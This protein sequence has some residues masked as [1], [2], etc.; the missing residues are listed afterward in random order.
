MNN[1]AAHMRISS[2]TV[3]DDEMAS[4][5]SAITSLAT[6][7]KKDKCA[8]SIVSKATAVAEALG[9]DGA[10]SPDLGNEVQLAIQKRSP[11]FLY[12]ERL[13][14]V[15]ICAG[16]SMISIL[17]N[18][19]S[20]S[21]WTTTDIYAVALWSA[22]SYQ[23]ALVAERREK[24]RSEVLDA[25]FDWCTTAAN[26]ARD[27]VD[28]PDPL[29]VEIIIHDGDGV[30]HNF[31]EAISKTI[32]ALRRNAALDREEL[33]FLWW[34]QLDRSRLLDKQFSAIAEP[35]RIVAAGIEGAKMLRRLPCEVHREIVLRTLDKNPE[36]DL[37]EMLAVIG[38]DREKLSA[39]LIKANVVAHPTVFPFLHALVCGEV[40]KIGA[41]QKRNVS[42]WGERALL[43]AG[44]ARLMSQGAGKV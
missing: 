29:D 39:S 16:M 40:D 44:L 27:R 4:R 11:S 9:G 10:P 12:E 22:L 21:E 30:S 42:E 14:D 26:K 31:K 34:A 17:D 13:L 1:L 33:D 38:D 35:T 41:S 20:T 5:Q 32:E 2:A 15:G 3:N 36:L 43:E 23:P 37:A 18:N 28:V 25:A 7:W 19:P 24:L 6:V 8:S